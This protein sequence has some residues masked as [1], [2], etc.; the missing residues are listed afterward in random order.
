QLGGLPLHL[1]PFDLTELVKSECERAR[2]QH[3]SLE[4]RVE[5]GDPLIVTAD[6]GRVAQV[7]S[8]L[9]ANA[10][11]YSIAPARVVSGVHAERD[12]A[13]VFVRDQGI[14]IP[15]DRQAR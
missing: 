1:E 14:G 2:A 9:L 12:H 7:V 5:T 15:V 3:R 13:I 4:L 10:V 11:K 8:R 6:R